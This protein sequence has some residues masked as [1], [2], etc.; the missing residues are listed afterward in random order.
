MGWCATAAA[1][2][3]V[4]L[5]ARLVGV[6]AWVV[7][8]SSAATAETPETVA[9]GLM[10]WRLAP[11]V[12]AAAGFTRLEPVQTGIAF[13]N[14]LEGDAF[15]TNAVANNGSGVAVGDV[16]G[17]SRPD[18]YF[19][20]LQGSNRLFLNRGGLRFE[21]HPIGSAACPDQMSTGA[22]LADVDGDGDFD[23]LVNGIASG[24]RLFLN[25]GRAGFTE[26]P[27]TGLSRSATP[28]SLALADIDGD[29]DLDL[30]CAHYSDLV[31]LAD[32]TVQVSVSRDGGV[33][34]IS[35]V[36]GQPATHPRWMGR[37]R[38]GPEGEVVEL[39]EADGLYR[40]EGGG[41]FTSITHQPGT[42]LDAGGR[43]MEPPRDW[44]LGVQF[45]DLDGD[46]APD[47]IVSNDNG[48][49]D[50]FWIN[51]GRGAFRAIAPDA[52]RHG[53]RS[54]M[55]LDV[56]DID[57]DGEDDILIVDMLARD[58]AARM[59]H[60]GRGGPGS[61]PPEPVEVRPVFNRNS[62][63]MG[64]GR[65]RYVETALMAGIAATDWSWC[66]AFV[67]VDLDGLEDLLVTN[68]FDQD[69][70]DQDANESFARRRWTPDQVRRHRQFYPR[71]NSA[72][73][74]FRNLG[75]GRFEPAGSS[76][77]FSDTEVSHGM[78]L[79]DLDGDGDLEPVVNV[80]NAPARIH[81]NN[82]PAP[83]VVVRLRGRVGN[84]HGIGA[85]I[86]WTGGGRTQ[87][88]EI[89]AGGRYLSGEP[90]ERVF[91]A[92]GTPGAI[93]SLEV[94]WRGGAVSRFEGLPAGRLYEVQEPEP[95]GRPPSIPQPPPAEPPP[96]FVRWEGWIAPVHSEA[97]FDD[98]ARQ[99][100]LPFRPGR[101]GPVLAAYDFNGDGW[102]DLLVGAGRGGRLAV[103]ASQAGKSFVRLDGAE[104]A[105]GDH[106]SLVGWDTGAGGHQ[107]LVGISNEEAPAGEP[108]RIQVFS[109]TAAPTLLA[110]GSS[111][112]GSIVLGDIDRDGDLDAF[113]AGRGVPGRYPEAASSVCLRNDLGTWS[114]ADDWSAPF[115]DLGRV[116]GAVFFDADN[117]GDGDL[118]VALEW[119]PLR[120]FLNQGGRFEDVSAAWGL[121]EHTGLWN[122]LAVGD[123]DGDGRLDLV[124]GNAGRNTEYELVQPARMGLVSGAWLGEGTLQAFEV[125]DDRGIWR[126]FRDRNWLATVLPDLPQRFPTH[127]AFGGATESALLEGRPGRARRL[128]VAGLESAVFLN[129]GG[130]FE[131]KVLPREAQ[132]SPVF[133]VAVADLDGDGLEDLV[134]GQN[135]SER[136]S[137]LSV[138][139]SGRGL[140]LRGTG[141]GAFR[142]VSPAQTGLDTEGDL[143][144]VVVLDADRDGRWDLAVSQNQGPVWLYR[145][146]TG[147]PGLGVVL[148]GPPA[149]PSGIGA[150]VRLRHADGTEGPARTV[151][152]GSGSGGQDGWRMVLA[153]PRPATGLTVRWP[154]GR[155]QTV[156]LEAGVSEVRVQAP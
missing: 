153:R 41:R 88:Q 87:S 117:D 139:D 3:R 42:F 128:E 20:A 104:V 59:R 25:D 77:G 31:A 18:V 85:R 2:S 57:R 36:N 142:A 30:Y 103:M 115:R 146:A 113:V 114:R 58:P 23:L 90:P 17:D 106:S 116:S 72:N 89:I 5:L 27:D 136:L 65:G 144:G 147:R 134:L 92:P 124:G 98:L 101:T 127:R 35:Q 78:A 46:L 19:C 10:A 62:L 102:E 111:A 133:A 108:S 43:P 149:N 84:R 82:S 120:C 22:V 64:R 66:P 34:R 1:R 135:R 118:A 7:T 150:M 61:T 148:S 74:A 26:P 54:S 152:A 154:G 68:G 99:P 121:S 141:A 28:M 11:A 16:D 50:R 81:R 107:F 29:G 63:F 45:R 122:C 126:P 55:G 9:P 105:A 129:R 6:V 12:G 94:R 39:P 112:I 131:R 79:A 60:A 69:V 96:Q 119:G 24:T 155:I 44:G 86:L 8:G 37:F 75:S 110:L 93:H 151:L 130:R 15:L 38:V 97:A 140:C 14:R 80:L 145:N 21:E 137:P 109:P 70:L 156:P 52:V 123:L 32:P 143:R 53:S 51:N 132:E 73:A 91:A 100:G 49:P 47:L 40:N 33:P 67:D 48:S 4:C 13:T 76:W 71:W 56:A 125:W 95:S 83:R 138:D